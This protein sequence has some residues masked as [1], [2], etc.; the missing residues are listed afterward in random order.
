M[1]FIDVMQWGILGLPILVI[2]FVI[3]LFRD[4]RAETKN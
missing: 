1:T 3:V 2:F 4:K